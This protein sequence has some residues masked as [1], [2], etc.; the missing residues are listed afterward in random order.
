[1]KILN[2]EK[3]ETDLNLEKEMMKEFQDPCDKVDYYGSNNDKQDI[4]VIGTDTFKECEL[5][6]MILH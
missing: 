5:K 3:Y 1:M 4:M 2:M 6:S